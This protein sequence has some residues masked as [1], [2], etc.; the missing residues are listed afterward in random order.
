MGIFTY[1]QT[2]LQSGCTGSAM[3]GPW[4]SEWPAPHACGAHGPRRAG[5][6]RGGAA[7]ALLCL[8]SGWR[9]TQGSRWVLL[10]PSAMELPVLAGD[11]EGLKDG[12]QGHCASRGPRSTEWGP[13]WRKWAKAKGYSE[14]SFLGL[15][16]SQS[17]VECLQVWGILMLRI[18][19]TM[20]TQ[21][22]TKEFKI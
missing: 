15:Q 22:F 16:S 13:C 7:A 12:L 4:S 1:L 3:M 8:V 5:S 11:A 18:W 6:A 17:P 10:P 14:A 20:R 9:W 21:I 19:K 2:L